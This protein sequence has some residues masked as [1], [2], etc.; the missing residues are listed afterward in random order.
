M[1]SEMSVVENRLQLNHR[2]LTLLN[3]FPEVRPAF[4]TGNV[5]LLDLPLIFKISSVK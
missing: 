1:G 4:E 2:K 5:I 3:F